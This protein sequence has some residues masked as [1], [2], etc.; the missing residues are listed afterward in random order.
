MDEE[1]TWANHPMPWCTHSEIREVSNEAQKIHDEIRHGQLLIHAHAEDG[2]TPPSRS[3]P[4]LSGNGKSIYPHGEDHPRQ[5]TDTFD[6]PAQAQ[7]AF[8]KGT[9]PTCAPALHP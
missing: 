3:A 1:W 2:Q 4:N 5:V 8:G 9:L 7:L 6:S